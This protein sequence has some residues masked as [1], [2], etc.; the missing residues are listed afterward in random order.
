MRIQS[1]SYLQALNRYWSAP[2]QIDFHGVQWDIRRT[3]WAVAMRRR[4]FIT[5]RGGVAAGRLR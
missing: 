2:A 4:H 1:R 3:R 5:L